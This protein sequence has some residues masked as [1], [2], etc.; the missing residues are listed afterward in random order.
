MIT[1]KK[2]K[3]ILEYNKSTGVFLWKKCRNRILGSVAGTI[4]NKG[5]RR[6]GINKSY[7][8]AH[9]LAWFYVYGEWPKSQLDHINR[10]RDDNRIDNLRDVTSQQNSRNRTPSINKFGVIGLSWCRKSNKFYSRI[11]V[12]RKTKYVGYYAS[13]LDAI[14]ARK[15]AENKYGF[16]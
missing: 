14:C 12:D 10:N 4:D 1:Q 13:M 5:Y 7:K 16:R 6:I 3:S 15:S 2:L 8:R 11:T 9:A